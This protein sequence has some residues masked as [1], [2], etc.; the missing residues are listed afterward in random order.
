MGDA[1]DSVQVLTLHVSVASSKACRSCNTW[2]SRQNADE[3]NAAGFKLYTA[4]TG[5]DFQGE[6]LKSDVFL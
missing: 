1:G 3:M 4:A 6:V 5:N 2:F